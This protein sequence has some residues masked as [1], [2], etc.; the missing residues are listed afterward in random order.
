MIRVVGV[1][2]GIHHDLHHHMPLQPDWA[3]SVTADRA[4]PVAQGHLWPFQGDAWW[5]H[6]LGVGK[7]QTPRFNYRFTFCRQR[8]SVA[9]AGDSPAARPLTQEGREDSRRYAEPGQ[10]PTRH[11][12]GLDWARVGTQLGHLL[13]EN[14]A[15][16]DAG[17]GKIALQLMALPIRSAVRCLQHL[18]ALAHLPPY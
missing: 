13:I 8:N 1:K 5:P 17:H 14:C 15:A 7:K 18:Q 6:S 12:R 2:K 16:S 9:V 11:R 4:S 3:A 10:P